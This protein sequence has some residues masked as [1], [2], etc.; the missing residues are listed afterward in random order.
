MRRIA[1]RANW[2]TVTLAVAVVALLGWTLA[3]DDWASI[4]GP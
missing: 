2:T 1:G 3:S 4:L